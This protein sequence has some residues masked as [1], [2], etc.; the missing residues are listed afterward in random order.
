MRCRQI[1]LAPPLEH[2]SLSPLEDAVDRI[3]PRRLV[4][5]TA[6]GA[7]LLPAPHPLPIELERWPALAQL[8]S[9]RTGT[10]PASLPALNGLRVS[11]A[12]CADID[13]LGLERGHR[14]LTVVRV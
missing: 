7:A 5:E 10:R 9:H 4:V 6:G 11:E 12:I 3:A 13:A 8:P 1:D 14:T 2:G